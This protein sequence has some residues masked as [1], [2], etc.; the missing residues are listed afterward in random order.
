MSGDSS[1]VEPGAHA[2]LPWWVPLG[3]AIVCAAEAWHLRAYVVDDGYIFLRFAHNLAHGGG[4]SFNPGHPIHATTSPLWALTVLPFE[5]LFARFDGAFVGLYALFVWLFAFAIATLARPIGL[6]MAALL[7]LVAACEPTLWQS[8]GLETALFL[9]SVAWVAVAHERA[10]GAAEGVGLGLAF[11]ARPDA[12]LLAVLVWGHSTWRDRQV[13][14]RSVC[15]TAALVVPWLVAASLMFGSP[16]P[17]TLGAKLAQA[18]LGWWATQPPFA[19]AAVE[20]SALG[21][22]GLTLA[23]L[24]VA[25]MRGCN[26][27]NGLRLFIAFGLTQ[28]L[29]YTVM[30]APT[31]YFWYYAPFVA[32]SAVG[33]SVGTS[34]VG[35]A[36]GGRWRRAASVCAPALA[37]L[38]IGV[39]CAALAKLP[40]EYRDGAEYRAAAAWIAGHSTADASI[41]ATE[42][43]TI[44]YYSDRPIVDLHGL[45]H[46]EA[47]AAVR[48]EDPSWWMAREPAWVVVHHPAWYAEPHFAKTPG[49]LEAWFDERYTLVASFGAGPLAVEVWQRTSGGAAALG[50]SP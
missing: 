25:P 10:A 20:A 38:V 12:A 8:S 37:A 42:I 22:M 17:S 49:K 15:C 24:A 27:H 21:A 26:G 18:S 33:A 13:P 16:I 31:G 39:E 4:W 35:F 11:L 40:T 9:A 50:G 47:R 23:I 44:G 28:L 36:L 30:R 43:G 46:P 6:T 2:A 48:A 29:A 34:R 7:G 3:L 5:S 19:V 1:K 14:W 32:A 45:I 41:A